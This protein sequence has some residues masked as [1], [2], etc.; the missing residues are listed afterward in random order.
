[1]NPPDPSALSFDPAHILSEDTRARAIPIPS[2]PATH[3][4]FN[5][6]LSID[7]IAS[8][9]SY[10]KRTTHSN[11]TG[12]DAATYDLLIE[13]DNNYLLPLFQRAIEHLDMPSSWSCVLKFASLLVHHKLCKALEQS[14]TIPHSQ[15]GFREG[16]CTNNNAFILCT[17]IEKAHSRGETI[18]AAFVDISN[19]F[20]STNQSSL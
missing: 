9:K 4:A 15:N 6:P 13:I 14:L 5:E 16:F 12:V 8:V 2:P 10:L 1:M 19:A 17:I 3:P 20:P 7:D 18:Y 11:S